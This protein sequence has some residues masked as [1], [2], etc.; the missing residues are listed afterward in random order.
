MIILQIL[1]RPRYLGKIVVLF[2]IEQRA[3]HLSPSG[4]SE[5]Q[6]LNYRTFVPVRQACCARHSAE[7]L[8][9]ASGLVSKDM[10]LNQ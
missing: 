8:E 6:I 9:E 5:A 3:Y 7:L 2:R 4:L 10:K 1:R